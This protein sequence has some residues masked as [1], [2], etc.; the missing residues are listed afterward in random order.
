MQIDFHLKNVPNFVGSGARVFCVDLVAKRVAWNLLTVGSILI[1]YIVFS[2]HPLVISCSSLPQGF[3]Q[4][5]TEAFVRLHE[6]GLV[7]RE[8]RL[9]NW[10]CALRSA[11]SDIEV[12]GMQLESN[13]EWE[14]LVYP[15]HRRSSQLASLAGGEQAAWGPNGALRPWIPGQ[16]AV[17]DLGDICLQS[18][19]SGG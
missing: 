7:Y 6:Q 11:L 14:I 18:G 19:R 13:R 12:S 4:A 17:W 10:S 3:S 16:G 1:G 5:V 9:V 15:L 2:P 8:K